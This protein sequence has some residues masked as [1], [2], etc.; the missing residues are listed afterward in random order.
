MVVVL[1]VIAMASGFILAQV[2]HWTYPTIQR[3]RAQALAGSI[4]AVLPG[5][6]EFNVIEAHPAG[7]LEDDPTT[8]RSKPG[9]DSD[10]LLLYQGLDGNGNPVGF[11]FVSEGAGYGGIVRIMVGVGQTDR[12]ISGVAI[13]EHAETPNL[14]SKIED[15]SFRSQFVGKGI[16]DP[17]AL[18]QD[19]DKISGATVSSRAVAEAVSRDLGSALQAYKE[20]AN[21]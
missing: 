6:V 18:G 11:A 20:A 14:G 7:G 17:I 15:E 19:I 13:L 10:P 3:N 8:L 1:T 12:L 21:Q 5:A 9:S 16:D 2:Y 4:L